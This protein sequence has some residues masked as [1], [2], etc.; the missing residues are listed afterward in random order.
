MSLI[1]TVGDSVSELSMHPFFKLENDS[2][3]F[4]GFLLGDI[5]EI[6]WTITV[7]QF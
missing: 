1:M 6:T 7:L 4:G 3:H 2:K 5:K